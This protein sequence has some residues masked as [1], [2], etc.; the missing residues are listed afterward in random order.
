MKIGKGNKEA[1]EDYNKVSFYKCYLR[2]LQVVGSGFQV[3]VLSLNSRIL[4]FII[5]W[6]LTQ[7][8]HNDVVLHE[9]DLILMF[10]IM[11]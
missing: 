2:N 9:E 5:V 3:G 11:N 1:L 6:I 10:C 7:R 4:A 8:G